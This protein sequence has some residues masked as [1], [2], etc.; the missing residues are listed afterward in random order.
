MTR[1]RGGAAVRAVV[2]D[3]Y[4]RVLVRPELVPCFEG[5]D[6]VALKRHRRC[7]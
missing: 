7:W 3:F 2:E 4:R 6:M 1:L 5:V